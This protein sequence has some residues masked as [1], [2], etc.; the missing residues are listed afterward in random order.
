[1]VLQTLGGGAQEDREVD[2]E[3]I[4]KENV[5]KWITIHKESGN[6]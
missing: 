1:M 2:T 6:M 5:D 4:T 3:L